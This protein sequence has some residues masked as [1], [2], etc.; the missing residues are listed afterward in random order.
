[1]SLHLDLRHWVNDL[2]M[3]VFFLMV[4]LEVKH[5]LVMGELHDPKQARLPLLAA[6]AGLIVPAAIFIAI[7]PGSDT[8]QA[9]GVVISTD[10]AFVLG[11]LALFG[12]G[13]PAPLRS[14]VLTLA[15]ADDVGALAVIA[16][17]YTEHLAIAPL[18]G[19]VVLAAIL[20]V[21]QRA[22][23]W[24]IGIYAVAALLVWLT[25]Y[26]SGVHATIAGVIVGLLLPVYPPQRRLISE[27]ESLTT[28]FRRTPTAVTGRAAAAGITRA[29]SV[30]ERVQRMISSYVVL[31]IV[32]IFAL[33]NAGVH[34]TGDILSQAWVSP[35]FWGLL[36]GL[37]AGKFIGVFGGT[38]LAAKLGIGKPVPGMK[39][40]HV[41]GGAMLTGIGFTISLFIIDLAIKDERLQS[42]ARIGV[43]IASV[44]A[45][46]VGVAIFGFVTRY[47]RAHAPARMRL[48]RPIET[49]SDHL[50]GRF[51]APLRLVEYGRFGGTDDDL[52]AEIVDDLRDRF[53]EDLCYVFRHNPL[54]DPV[55][56]QAAESIEAVSD[57]AAP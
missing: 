42:Q 33:A 44:V 22:N 11:L 21:M 10:T 46:A 7:N 6:I 29:I 47:D 18:I 43:L 5:D 48:V 2:L 13:I 50:L 38:V 8:T 40:R 19:A 45:G 51:T 15:V 26:A 30:N 31:L 14:F 20:F 12:N 34:I 39:S 49:D 56:Q 27:A 16:L 9:W 41:A 23:V 32:P 36:A 52:V 54:G 57:Q 53:D 4:S 25:V 3:A 24:R 17:V 1:A 55:A 35:L 37:V 28:A